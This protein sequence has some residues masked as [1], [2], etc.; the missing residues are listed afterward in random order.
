MQKKTVKVYKYAL[1]SIRCACN[2]NQEEYKKWLKR[3]NRE[4]ENALDRVVF[5]NNQTVYV[6]FSKV[7]NH[8]DD[9]GSV[10]ESANLLLGDQMA[11]E[12]SACMK[13]LHEQF[14]KEIP[15]LQ[16]WQL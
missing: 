11:I 5:D 8:D 6:D 4:L 14:N 7:R 13:H 15:K 9:T 1:A 10:Y 2:D 16:S 3:L 12:V